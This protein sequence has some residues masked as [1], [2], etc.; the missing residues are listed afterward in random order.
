MFELIYAGAIVLAF[1]VGL[2]F[3]MMAGIIVAVWFSELRGQRPGRTSWR[4]R[5]IEIAI[6]AIGIAFFIWIGNTVNWDFGSSSG[7]NNPYFD[8]PDPWEE[9]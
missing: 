2:V 7:S 9:K 5:C 3:I 4:F 6:V 1:I 8:S